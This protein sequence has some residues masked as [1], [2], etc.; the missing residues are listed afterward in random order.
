MKVA[1]SEGDQQGIIQRWF[2]VWMTGAQP[3]ESLKENSSLKDINE[4]E[5]MDELGL[6]IDGDN[7]LLR[8]RIFAQVSFHLSKSTL[9]LVSD[10]QSQFGSEPL[11]EIEVICLLYN[12]CYS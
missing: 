5:L 4:E 11:I 6:E 8:D 3:D 2:P 12:I 7:K 1:D 10:D 9:Q